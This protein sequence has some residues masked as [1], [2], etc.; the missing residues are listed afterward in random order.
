MPDSKSSE[1]KE[2][3]AGWKNE[4]EGK[5]YKDKD[6][7]QHNSKQDMWISVHGKGKQ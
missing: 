4:I 7:A 6:L 5:V 3:K 1:K 2:L